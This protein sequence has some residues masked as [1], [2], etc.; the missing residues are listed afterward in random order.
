VDH[1]NAT[2]R[3]RVTAGRAAGFSPRGRSAF[4][5]AELMIALVILGLGLLFIAAAL[6][7]GLEYTRETVDL[8]NAEAAGEYALD[9]L[10]TNLRTSIRLYDWGIADPAGANVLRLLDNIHR[11]RDQDLTSTPPRYPLNKT[12]EPVFKVRPVAMGNVRMGSVPS[13]QT[14][15]IVDDVEATISA[16]IRA[17]NGAT[18]VAP[19]E[20]D[21]AMSAHTGLSLGENPVLP[22]LARV[23]PPTEPVTTLSVQ[24]FFNDNVAY[25]T[26][27][28]RLGL[29]GALSATQQQNEWEKALDRRLSWTVFYRR[30]HYPEPGPD[31]VFGTADDNLKQAVELQY[32]IIIVVAQRPSVNHRFPRQRLRLSGNNLTEFE[33]PAAWSPN[34]PAPDDPLVGSDRLA[35]T[36][37][38]VVF[39]RSNPSA[40]PLL[41]TSGLYDTTPGGNRT[42][43]F[44][45][46]DPPTLTFRCTQEVGKLLA[47]GSILIPAFNDL[48]YLDLAQGLD[49]RVSG[50][51]P[52]APTTLPIYEVVE[53]PD[54]TTIVVRNNGFY[55]W[56]ASGN[57][58]DTQA[59]PVWVIPPAFAERDSTGQPIYERSSPILKVIR[60]TVTLH[61][62]NR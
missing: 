51:V 17:L 40:L 26:Y 38:L 61:E 41:N 35:P 39:D 28:M 43:Y 3:P 53:R 15:E 47:E 60:R 5:L 31:N 57:P 42:L 10:E 37:W 50:F 1:A 9:Q 8:E 36:P 49:T 59:W 58:S 32:E 23:Y 52:H 45:F 46:R 44:S 6:P 27:Q 62:I 30:I 33:R 55:P 24:N 34:A 21:I 16:Y 7:V 22:G 12:Y 54:D 20:V 2:T 14:R 19:L 48:H 18:P 29:Y 56:V 13:G 11:P 25:K 4:S